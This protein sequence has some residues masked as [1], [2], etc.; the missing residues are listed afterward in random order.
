[1]DIELKAKLNG[2]AGIVSADP[3]Q[4]EQVIMNL[5]VNARDAMPE[6]G[7]LTIATRYGEWAP[8]QAPGGCC[9]GYVE[10]AVSDTGTGMDAETLSRIFEPFFTTK[11]SGKGTGL[12]LSVVHGIVEQSGGRI[13]V[14]SRPGEGA[15]FRVYLP[16]TNAPVPALEPKVMPDSG[17][18]ETILVVE[19]QPQVL[20]FTAQ[21]LA[22]CGYNVIRSETAG[23]ALVIFEAER[24]RIDL[25]LTDVVMPHMSGWELSGRLRAIEPD[26]KV[27]YMSG[28]A[29]SDEVHNRIR[30]AGAKL[31]QKPFTPKE[32]ATGVREALG[33]ARSCGR[34]LV[35]DD[36]GSVRL[37]LRLVLERAGYRVAEAADGRQ[38]MNEARRRKV[39]LLLTD[40]VMP[41]QEGF[42]TIGNFRREMPEVKIIAMSGRFDSNYLR[43]AEMLGA[44]AVISKPIDVELLLVRITEVLALAK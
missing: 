29:D 13:E 14:E 6:G 31:I 11:E 40:I 18:S 38:A 24:K 37:F 3:S 36:E 39:D 23:D 21:A 41:E 4:L 30:D 32:L 15:T 42:E 43:L 35:V 44:H 28:Y 20:E 34:I 26:V 16:R 19:D 7:R 2:G 8:D 33:G 25:V 1:E 5:V 12:G 22:A 9:G 10:L 17:G 27:L